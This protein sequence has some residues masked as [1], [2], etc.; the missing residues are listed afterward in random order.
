MTSRDSHT[1]Q[2]VP[3]DEA[4]VAAGEGEDATA[5]VGV[6]VDGRW[7]R[8]KRYYAQRWK[9]KDDHFTS[10]SAM[11]GLTTTTAALTANLLGIGIVAMPFAFD[12][13]GWSAILIVPLFAALAVF[14]AGM[15][16]ACCKMMEER[17]KEYRRFHW[18][19]HYLDITSKAL[20]PGV[21]KIVA[22]VRLLSVVGL[23]AVATVIASEAVTDFMMAV[24]PIPWM[25]GSMYCTC[26]VV[27]G[28]L[29]AAING[30]CSSVERYWCSAVALPLPLV[31]LSLL[32]A[33]I[34]D[35]F[36]SPP[37]QMPR[38]LTPSGMFSVLSAGRM[39]D[40]TSAET[41]F[42][43]LGVIAF[44]YASVAGFTH[45]RRDMLT[46]ASFKRAASYSVTGFTV[47]CLLVGAMGY[48]AFGSRLNGNVVLT[49]TSPKTRL[50]ADFFASICYLP[51]TNLISQIL[52]ERESFEDYGKRTVWKR[53]KIASPLMACACLLALAVPHAGLLMALVGSLLLCPIAFVL[54]PIFYAGLCRGSPQWPERYR[55]WPLSRNLKIA[56]A[57]AMTIGIVVHIGGTVTAIM[58]IV[59]HFEL[60]RQSCLRGF[61]YEKQFELT[62]PLQAYLQLLR[63]IV[64]G[65]EHGRDVGKCIDMDT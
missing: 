53:A 8:A 49:F 23:Q 15:L 30:P 20:G 19:T 65:T 39:S 43:G 51:T 31:L 10:K 41:F 3:L 54:P 63:H 52:E 24:V 26:V 16:N 17:R 25:H 46:P 60:D 18:Y 9:K 13:I 42:V 58:K 57:L 61:C 35:R 22:A 62:P 55:K 29:G 33:G 5:T 12:A 40:E 14:N 21:G 34:A 64:A 47:A 38:S 11:L 45:I 2:V 36:E 1:F 32:L 4:G 50:A 6:T 44:N 28:A 7:R 37:I 59:K 48:G 27:F 56:M